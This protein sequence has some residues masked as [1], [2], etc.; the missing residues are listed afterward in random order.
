MC[1]YK[2]RLSLQPHFYR[3]IRNKFC[4]KD[5][6]SFMLLYIKLTFADALYKWLNK[7]TAGNG[8]GVSG[9]VNIGNDPQFYSDYNAGY[10]FQEPAFVAQLDSGESFVPAASTSNGWNKKK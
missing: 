3:R 10:T 8:Y 4:R 6:I 9:G 2:T 1:Y 5:G 7:D